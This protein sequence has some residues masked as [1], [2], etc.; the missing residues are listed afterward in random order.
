MIRR[1]AAALLIASL[2]PLLTCRKEVREKPIRLNVVVE[3]NSGLTGWLLATATT[4]NSKP[5]ANS[6]PS[7]Q[8]VTITKP[9]Y[10]TLL[11]GLDRS[12]SPSIVILGAEI[13]RTYATRITLADG[14]GT[15]LTRVPLVLVTTKRAV[16]ISNTSALSLTHV[17]AQVRRGK[18]RLWQPDPERTAA[19]IAALAL[20][21]YT[22]GDLSVGTGRAN[23]M[24]LKNVVG[25]LRK[26]VS[27]TP[28]DSLVLDNEAFGLIPEDQCVLWSERSPLNAAYPEEG[29][30]GIEYRAFI[31]KGIS[32]QERK[33]ANLFLQFLTTPEGQAIKS[34]YSIGKR[35]SKSQPAKLLPFPNPSIS[36]EMLSL[37]R[38][39]AEHRTPG[40]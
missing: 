19:G 5:H 37:W 21:I 6:D 34:N 18:R 12:Y 24:K 16:D 9:D 30:V 2:L 33:A 29:T 22:A 26:V 40:E 17:L 4:F 11:G 39:T 31:V 23:S 20:E 3:A 28:E 14:D 8:L 36:A 10:P 15:P 1:L 25:G 38:E 35:C 32:E 27:L 7:I 13:E